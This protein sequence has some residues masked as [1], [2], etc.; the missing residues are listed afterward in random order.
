MGALVIDIGGGTTNFAVYADG[1]IK[2]TGV[3][4]VGGDHVSNDL[5]YGLKV[6]LGRA[7][8]LK[9]EHG[10]ALMDDGVKGQTITIAN[11]LGL[12]LKTINLEHLRR[13]MS[14]RLEEILQLIEQDIARAELL[15]YLRAGVF[16]CGGGARIPQITKLAER[17]FQMPS[18]LGKANS[19]NGIKSA[20]DQPEFATA[21]GLVKFGS[22]QQK[23][24]SA[25][26][27]GDGIKKTWTEIFNRK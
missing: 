17:V 22:F 16:I 5:A 15:D 27:F 11:E 6:P 3:L 4:A 23:K 14:M 21:I 12:P 8:Q 24:R 19:I 18:S 9:I 1:I 20:L 10:S 7:E 25:G 2:H 13:V 26:F